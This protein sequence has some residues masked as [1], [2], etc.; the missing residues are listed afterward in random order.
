[1]EEY[2]ELATA[3][4]GDTVRI[5][6]EQLGISDTLRIVSYEYNVYQ[7]VLARVQIGNVLRE[8]QD[9]KQEIDD[10]QKQL[11]DLWALIGPIETFKIGNENMLNYGSDETA[12]VKAL[13][14]GSIEKFE[15]S[16][17]FEA[18]ENLKGIFFKLYEKFKEHYVTLIK[19]ITNKNDVVTFTKET[20]NKSENLEN[21]LVPDTN[22]K[23]SYIFVVTKIPYNQ[24]TQQNIDDEYI[25]AFGVTVK[26]YKK[27]DDEDGQGGYFVEFETVTA[28][29][30]G[31]RF[32]FTESYNRV[33]SVAIGLGYV[34][35]EEP[36][37]A[38]WKAIVE[39]EE[40]TGV[41]VDVKGLIDA[42]IDVSIQAVCFREP[43][44]EEGAEGGVVNG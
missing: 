18:K 40:V 44:N 15:A 36:V 25:R 2:E 7:K 26:P 10:T 38:H 39:G 8:I 28:T 21:V 3:H 33:A 30:G 11:L 29:A 43:E 41:L 6:D 13:I 23:A 27:D 32:D 14:K 1:M 42:E 31:A 22:K 5:I 19:C 34:E 16:G 20:W 4:I 17:V 12:N 24:L 37:A 9:Y 35:Q